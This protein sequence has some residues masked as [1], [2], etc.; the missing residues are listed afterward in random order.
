MSLPCTCDLC[1]S[2]AEEQV[3]TVVDTWMRQPDGQ[4]SVAE[5]PWREW[6]VNHYTQIRRVDGDHNMRASFISAVLLYFGALHDCD[7]KKWNSSE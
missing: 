6:I 7:R 4:T 5:W 3:R 1:L 2:G